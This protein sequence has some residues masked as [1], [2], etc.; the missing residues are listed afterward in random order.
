MVSGSWLYIYPS[1]FNFVLSAKLYAATRGT[2][3]HPSV[4]IC[5]ENTP[6]VT[7][8]I[9]NMANRYSLRDYGKTAF[10]DGTLGP[11]LPNPGQDIARRPCTP[12]VL[13]CGAMGAGKSTLVGTYTE[14]P[15]VSN[16]KLFAITDRS[17]LTQYR[18]E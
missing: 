11:W 10:R 13:V 18:P 17:S 15:T 8:F 7:N 14:T 4:F 2:F 1:I 5:D 6:D 3:I 12:R 16:T 9:N